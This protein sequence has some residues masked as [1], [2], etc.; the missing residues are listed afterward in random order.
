MIN[1]GMYADV[2]KKKNVLTYVYF[3]DLIILTPIVHT[4]KKIIYVY[5]CDY[6]IKFQ[7]INIFNT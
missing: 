6:K 4:W 5:M 1:V 7:N 3:C 2:T